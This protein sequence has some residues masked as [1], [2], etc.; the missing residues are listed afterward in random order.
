MACTSDSDI[1]Y[2]NEHGPGVP[3]AVPKSTDDG[4]VLCGCCGEV[5]ECEKSGNMP[6]KCPRCKFTLLWAYWRDPSQDEP[7]EGDY[8][9]IDD[10][11]GGYVVSIAG[12]QRIRGARALSFFDRDE[13]EEVIRQDMKESGVYPDVWF[14]SDHGNLDRI[15]IRDVVD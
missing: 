15:D 4:L 11:R 6:E 13:A 14:E 3:T 1:E 5:L 9:I 7:T 10:A 2:Y 12:G 8:I